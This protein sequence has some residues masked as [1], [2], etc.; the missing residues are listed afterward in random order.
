MYSSEGRWGFPKG[1]GL[2]RLQWPNVSRLWPGLHQCASGPAL[3]QQCRCPGLVSVF[4]ASW[5]GLALVLALSVCGAGCPGLV[6]IEEG[7]IV[8]AFIGCAGCPGLCP[9]S[10]YPSGSSLVLHATSGF[11]RVCMEPA[12]PHVA[13]ARIQWKFWARGIPA[14]GE[15]LPPQRSPSCRTEW[16]DSQTQAG[17]DGYLLAGSEWSESVKPSHV[18]PYKYTSICPRSDG[19]VHLGI[20]TFRVRPGLVGQ[21]VEICCRVLAACTKDPPS[22][23]TE[24][25]F[26]PEQIR[27]PICTNQGGNVVGIYLRY[28]LL[29]FRLAKR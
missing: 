3:P 2:S 1:S 4:P 10:R 11:L 5:S 18:W 28:Y 14:I 27:S 6:K 22:W 17:T 29:V 19:N 20:H 25:L 16:H 24:G 21:V 23:V 8:P 7:R 15:P 9:G 26:S 12:A 13:R